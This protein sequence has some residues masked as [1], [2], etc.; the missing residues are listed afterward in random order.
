MV[1]EGASSIGWGILI[2]TVVTAMVYLIIYNMYGKDKRF[3]PI[4]FIIAPILVALLTYQCSLLVGAIKVKNQCNDIAIMINSFLPQ[5]V[6]RDAIDTD[7][8]ENAIEQASVFFPVLSELID[9]RAIRMDKSSSL[10]KAITKNINSKINWFIV[11]RVLLSL[12]FVLIATLGL[13]KS[14]A[15]AYN[16]S[17]VRRSRPYQE[18]KRMG[19]RR[20]RR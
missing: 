20:K 18:R 13:Y 14:L 11:R 15:L 4:S 10:G 6:V 12:L 9:I 3:T 19:N 8:L 2:A 5:N 16:T 17:R 1:I 7:E